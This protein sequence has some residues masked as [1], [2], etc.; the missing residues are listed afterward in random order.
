MAQNRTAELWETP[1]GGYNS[2]L[3]G[4]QYAAM[5]RGYAAAHHG[6][7]REARRFAHDWA[8]GLKAHLILCIY[9]YEAPQTKS[10]DYTEEHDG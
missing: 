4:Q 2:R 8:R 9:R 1:D 5:P 10:F 7:L 6:S 3:Y